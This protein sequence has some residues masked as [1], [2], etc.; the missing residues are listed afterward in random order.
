LLGGRIQ[1]RITKHFPHRSDCLDERAA[2]SAEVTALP[3]DGDHAGHVAEKFSEKAD[4]DS[5]FGE[6][7]SPMP[8]FVEWKFLKDL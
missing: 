5:T 2:D 6:M 3:F 4:V 8:Q 1:I 7:E